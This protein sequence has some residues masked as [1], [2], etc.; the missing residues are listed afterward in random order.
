MQPSQ[1]TLDLSII[2]VNHNG[3]GCLTG[4]LAA[5]REHTAANRVECLVVDSG[6]TDG[7]WLEVEEQWENARAVRFEENIGFCAGCNR[8]AEIA[9]ADLIAFVNFDSLVEAD[10]DTP[11]RRAL[12]SPDISIA[13]GLLLRPDGATVEAAGLAIAPNTAT[14]GLAEDASRESV[15]TER[16]Y[17][18]AASGAL[19]MVRRDEFLRLGGFYEAI[20][21]YGE[22][23]DLC[24][25]MPGRV[26]IDP[27]S[28]SCHEV[29]HAAGP[30]RSSLRLYWPSRNRLINSARHLTLGHMI[31]SVV[32]SA[33]FDM[34]AVSQ[35][36]TRQAGSAICR[37]WRDGPR[38][39]LAER[40][41][42][43]RD[44]RRQASAKLVSIR[45]SVAQQRRLG[46]L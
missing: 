22:E 35:V 1:T 29:G 17:T 28:A 16:F 25:R 24:L 32:A 38:M 4:A 34:L 27:R 41:A 46:R 39:M 5:L 26:V 31:L 15:G 45:D 44:E 18:A 2:L 8:G 10:W 19:M 13:G 6:S 7:S 12:E 37:G 14:F 43:S 42:R 11:L 36:R 40:H 9:R 33:A 20:W 21:M 23:A 30:P 3:A